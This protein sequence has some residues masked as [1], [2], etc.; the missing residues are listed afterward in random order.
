MSDQCHYN[1]V[2]CDCDAGVC[3]WMSDQCHY[4]G[5][6]CDCDAG[7]CV[8]VRSVSLQWCML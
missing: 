2:C 3:V 5:V 6:C 1:G 7:V 8:D 4:N